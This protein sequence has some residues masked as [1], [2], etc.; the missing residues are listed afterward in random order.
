MAIMDEVGQFIGSI[1]ETYSEIIRAK[2]DAET[3]QLTAAVG[4]TQETV[5]TTSNGSN[6]VTTPTAVP[7]VQ[8]SDVIKIGNTTISKTTALV[9]GGVLAA[10]VLILLVKK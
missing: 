8:N 3:P 6:P 2:A 1:G 4:N 5:Q 10:L 9:G 7:P